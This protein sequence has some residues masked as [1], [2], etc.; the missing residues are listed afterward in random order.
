MDLG[1][2]NYASKAGEGI[3]AIYVLCIIIGAVILIK[4]LVDIYIL[5]K[6]SINVRVYRN[7]GTVQTI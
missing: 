3:L 6:H 2:F 4:Y 1:I 7:L 5:K